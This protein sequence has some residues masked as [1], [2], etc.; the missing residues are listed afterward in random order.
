M[1]VLL[2]EIEVRVL[3]ALIEK[4]LT[5]PEYYPLT[6]NSLVLACNQK[7]N[8]HPVTSYNEAQVGD[9]LELLRG[10]NLAY[11]FY[12]STN[13]VPKYKHVVPENFELNAAETAVLCVLMLRGWQTPGELRGRTDRLHEFSSLEQIDETLQ[14][15]MR[16]DPALVTVLPRQVG[17][18]EARY[19]HLLCGEI[20]ASALEAEAHLT[21]STSRD[22]AAERLTTLET[23]FAG[24]RSDLNQ[25][26]EEF[27]AFRKEFS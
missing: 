2:S 23:E 20:P 16:R 7:S 5:T 9:A 24:V 26:R 1:A 19:A 25:L 18:K 11:V 22:G 4:Q 13:R 21:R 8:R 10:R 27:E 17:Q 3:G 12:G 15:L 6:L 14:S